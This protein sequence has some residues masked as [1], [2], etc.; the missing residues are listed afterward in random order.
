MIDKRII[1]SI[2]KVYRYLLP[3]L[4]FILFHNMS[5]INNSGL[6]EYL[7]NKG[8]YIFLPCFGMI[9]Y[10]IHRILFEIIDLIIHKLFF[11]A[12]L[13]NMLT[14]QGSHS[15]IL[16]KYGIIFIINGP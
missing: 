16:K 5:Y 15:D 11:K 10:A 14:S 4:L 3:G 6:S 1:D 2:E 9:V 13:L 7:G 12:S 8:I